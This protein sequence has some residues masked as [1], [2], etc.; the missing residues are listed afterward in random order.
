MLRN[1]IAF[2]VLIGLALAAQAGGFTPAEKASLADLGASVQS[3][4]VQQMAGLRARIASEGRPK[5]L[6]DLFAV[7]DW[8]GYCPCVSTTLQSIVTPQMLRTGSE[9]DGAAA[10]KRA[11]TM[12]AVGRVKETFSAGCAGMM[13]GLLAQAGASAAATSGAQ[14]YCRCLQSDID[15]LTADTFDAVVRATLTDYAAYTRTRQLPSSGPSL[16]A[17]MKR[18]GVTDLPNRRDGR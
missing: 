7:A 11:G 9:Q 17:A 6:A 4:C 8:T 14:G 18:C 15:A 2:A 12:C 10:V 16:L 3:E 5:G 1:L 13:E